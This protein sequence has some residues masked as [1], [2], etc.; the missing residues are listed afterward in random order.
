[1]DSNLGK[2]GNDL[3]LRWE[4]RALLEFEV[5][6]SAGQC[7][8]AVDTTK[9]DETSSGTNSCLL[10]CDVS[11]IC[12]KHKEQALHTLVLRLVVERQ[13]LRTALDTQYGPRISS[14]GLHNSVFI[15]SLFI[16]LWTYHVDLILCAYRD[17]CCTSG[18]FLLVSWICCVALSASC[19]I[20]QDLSVRARTTE[21]GSVY[22]QK[23][24]LKG[25]L[26]LAS[27]ERFLLR[28]NLVEVLASIDSDLVTS[29]A[30]IDTEETD[31]NV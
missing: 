24:I 5:S 27:L 8:V 6:N 11:E 14:I 23:A 30:V 25:L 26:K 16:I 3:L 15:S 28:D 21:Y 22:C 29:V 12:V 20:H 9:V 10:A 1:M 4:V 17:S 13:W 2:G 7:E 31:P 19:T 18:D